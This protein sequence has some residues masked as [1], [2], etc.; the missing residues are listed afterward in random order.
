MNAFNLQSNKELIRITSANIFLKLLINGA[1]NNS[2]AEAFF[3]FFPFCVIKILIFE[4][5]VSFCQTFSN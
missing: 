5:I 2:Q 1:K 4:E 3:T